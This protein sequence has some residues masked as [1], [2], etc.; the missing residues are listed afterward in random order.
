[1][2]PAGLPGVG[3]GSSANLGHD[4]K[5]KK[6]QNRN[7]ML[8]D[9]PLFGRSDRVFPSFLGVCLSAIRVF[10]IRQTRTARSIHYSSSDPNRA[11]AR[12]PD[13][14]VAFYSVCKSVP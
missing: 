4:R 8:R 12:P 3:T 10:N 5:P 1:M 9:C 14:P 7:F 11:S 13:S 2:E 6:G